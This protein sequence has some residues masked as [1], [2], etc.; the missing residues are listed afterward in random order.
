MAVAFYC[1][2]V[3]FKFPQQAKLKKFIANSYYTATG[4][5]LH[6]DYVFCSDEYRLDLNNRHLGHDYYTD[7]ITFDLS[8]NPK[9]TDAEIYIS[10]DRV[11][12]NATK[13]QQDMIDEFHRVL[14]HGVLHLAGY[15]DHSKKEKAQMRKMEEEW[16]M[17]YKKEK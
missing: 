11:Q 12:D 7:I 6:L 8:D 14:F 15:L 17:A 9:K 16:M 5:R 3:Q 13:L 4:K 10:I 1:A 2:D